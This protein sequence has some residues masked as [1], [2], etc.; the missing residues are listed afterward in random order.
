MQA[1]PGIV[2]LTLGGLL[3]AGYVADA[4]G[5]LTA[6]PRVTLMVLFGVALGPAALDLIPVAIETWYEL[7]ADIALVMVG[8]VLG[9]RLEPRRLRRI[10]RA[11]LA[12]S[13]AEV[14]GVALLVGAGLLA[15][16]V[17]PALALL[18]AGIAPASAPA[19]IRD[20]IG[21][22]RASGP[23]TEVVSG[24]VAVDDAW[25][26]ILFSMLLA[27][28]SI[29]VGGGGA[30][31]AL[32]YGL[33]EVGGALALGVALGLPGAALSGRVRPGEPTRIEALGLV[34][35]CGGLALS[36]EVSFLLAAMVMG[37]VIA[38]TARHHARPREA[39][40]EVEQPVLVLFFILA[41]ASLEVARLPEIGLVGLAYVALRAGGLWL[42]A[43]GGTRL[44]GLDPRTGPLVGIAIL[45]QA[46]VA[47]GMALVAAAR[48][49]GVGEQLLAIV[50]GSTVVFELIGPLATRWALSRAGET[51]AEPADR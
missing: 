46:G 47:L 11:V 16:G 15:L 50:I 17:A 22:T 51:G 39:I 44:G 35:L 32:L 24:V 41:G 29:W 34:L 31:E 14:A 48:F 10:G 1:E 9:L 3:L 28:A 4:L 33:R 30:G 40:E 37:A 45:P 43:W 6:A 21:Q 5:R 26:L 7:T 12:V 8:F 2:L 38:N 27:V 13:L 19:A 25:G 49:P 18:L 20:V 36:L 23:V 42:G